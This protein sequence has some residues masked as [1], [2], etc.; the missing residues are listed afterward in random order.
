MFNAYYF[1]FLTMC[2]ILHTILQSEKVFHFGRTVKLVKNCEKSLKYKSQKTG[3]ISQCRLFLGDILK[4][5]Y[6]NL[7]LIIHDISTLEN[8]SFQTA[9]DIFQTNINI[10]Y[11]KTG[12][13][14]LNMPK[15]IHF[16]ISW[17]THKLPTF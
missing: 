17:L 5:K 3:N 9:L 4:E 12:S 16:G 8:L 11:A 14:N 13:H 2:I 10:I 6:F 1:V 7:L 15:S